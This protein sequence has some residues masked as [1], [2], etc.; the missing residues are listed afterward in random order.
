MIVKKIQIAD[1]SARQRV[2]FSRGNPGL[3]VWCK[4]ICYVSSCV[5]AVSILSYLCAVNSL[6]AKGG[7]VRSV[8]QAIGQVRHD[9]EKMKIREAELRSLYRIRETAGSLQRIEPAE[10][11]YVQE[12]GAV[13]LNR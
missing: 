8:E 4:R 2:S 3:R 7:E 13:A 11:G 1:I 6:A 9:F 5:F 10:V 12:K